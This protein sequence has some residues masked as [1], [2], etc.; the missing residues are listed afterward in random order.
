V[1]AIVALAGL[2]TMF[3]AAARFK[4]THILGFTGLLFVTCVLVAINYDIHDIDSYFLLAF[5]TLA[6]WVGAGTTALVTYFIKP[7]QMKPA[8]AIVCVA[9]L[10]G[11]IEIGMNHK[12]VDE[13][14]NYVVEDFTKNVLTNLPPHAIVFSSL[15]DF[16]VSGAFYYQMVE[17]IRPDVLVIDK[18]MLRDRPWNYAQLMQRDKEPFMRAKPEMD[19]FLR[20]LWAFDRGE[21][22]NPEAIA[23]A[24]QAFTTALVEK[25][26]DRPIF[27]TQE[28]LDQR[29]DLFAPNFKPVPA[30]MLYRLMPS[31]TFL[32]PAAP[33]IQW[34]SSHY[35]KRNYY[36]D[37]ARILQVT[38]IAVCA[39]E[40][41]R[42]HDREHALAFV[43]EALKLKPDLSVNP[44]DLSERDASIAEA[45]NQRFQALENV[46]NDLI[47]K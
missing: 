35:S 16:W 37:D 20:Y 40:Y 23:P 3:N 4:R 8:V 1:G 33:R 2:F 9:V 38:P 24:Y 11:A 43:N 7:E 41:L 6:I 14:G 30:G 31:D 22:F 39:Q 17:H 47:R 46:R 32:A 21:P 29:D 18:A 28:M 36:T 10:I 34:N 26:M 5:L 12:D 44:E 19:N 42:R 25:N 45:A 27:V 15:W 13:S